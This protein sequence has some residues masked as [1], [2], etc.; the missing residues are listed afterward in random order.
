MK[1]HTETQICIPKHGIME[2][3]KFIVYDKYQNMAK[4]GIMEI[5]KFIV[6]DEYQNMEASKYKNHKLRELQKL[7][8]L[9]KIMT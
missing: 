9:K 2:I 1:I 5:Q 4:H 6:Y 3:Q 7:L 8:K